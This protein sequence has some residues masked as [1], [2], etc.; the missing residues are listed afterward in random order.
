[1]SKGSHRQ[2]GYQEKDNF[3]HSL[4]IEGLLGN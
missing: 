2:A 1:L 3:L 4:K